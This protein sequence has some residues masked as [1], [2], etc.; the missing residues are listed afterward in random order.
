M[1][2]RF[3]VE[4]TAPPDASETN[5]MDTLKKWIGPIIFEDSHRPGSY[6]PTPS[7]KPS[8]PL[9]PPP[10]PPRTWLQWT[11]DGFTSLFGSL[12]PSTGKDGQTV[13][14]E[15]ITPS[16]MF[17]RPRRPSPNEFW[18]GEAT[19]E[20]IKVSYLSE[21]AL[22][23]LETDPGDKSTGRNDGK[24]RLLETLCRYS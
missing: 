1:I 12:I 2:V 13:G 9:P 10:P 8:P 14:G 15:A 16:S 5:W 6:V 17:R 3:W 20:L 21:D 11:G 22:I 7:I 18:T 23:F 19:A 4:G 24:L